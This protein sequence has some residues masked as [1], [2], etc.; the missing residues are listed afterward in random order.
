MIKHL[1]VHKNF[2]SLNMNMRYIKKSI[3]RLI[4]ILM[5]AGIGYLFYEYH[6]DKNKKKEP[7]NHYLEELRM[8]ELLKNAEPTS[9]ESG[10]GYTYDFK[11]MIK[12]MNA[13]SKVWKDFE[14]TFESPHKRIT[15]EKEYLGT[16]LQ[17]LTHERSKL[18]NYIWDLKGY[19]KTGIPIKEYRS[20]LYYLEVL[21]G[22]IAHLRSLI[23]KREE[24]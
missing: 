20:L 7:T 4:L 8:R 18:K 15:T 10:D 3:K 16:L 13:A 5:V 9:F 1:F 19:S 23:K 6:L 17:E 11:R 24:K 12:L 21:D 14:P 2:S 22:H